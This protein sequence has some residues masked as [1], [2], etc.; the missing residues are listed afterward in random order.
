MTDVQM[1]GDLLVRPLSGTIGAVIEGVDLRDVSDAEVAA[2]RQTWLERKVVFF[3][4]QHLDPDTHLAFASRFGELTEGHPVIPGLSGNPNIFQIDYSDNREVYA[5]YGDAARTAGLDWHTDVTFVRRP[6]MGSILSAVTIPPSGGDTMFS[7]QAAAFAALSPRMQE[8]LCTLTAV[9]DGQ[10]AFQYALDFIGAGTWEGEE[11]TM[12][13]QVVHPVVRTHPE[14]GEKALFVN[15]AFT[16]HIV[17]LDLSESDALLSFLYRH[18]VRPEFTVRYH[19]TTGDV[20]FWDNRSTQHAV[21]GDY[22]D[23]K[24]VIQRVTL[25]G[26]EPR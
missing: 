15:P 3:T 22:G 13:E 4:G 1:R 24:R 23:Q 26:D 19:W 10:Q 20:G 17:E 18:A 7:D 2:I 16:K 5:S 21:V 9:H 12:L 11:V 14:T 6:P 25:R 8:F